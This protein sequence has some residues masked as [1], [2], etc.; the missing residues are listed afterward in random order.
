MLL[1]GKIWMWKISSSSV[2]KCKKKERYRHYKGLSL[3]RNV[4][5]VHNTDIGRGK[6]KTRQPESKPIVSGVGCRRGLTVNSE[7]CRSRYTAILIIFFTHFVLMQRI[8]INWK[9]R[10][11]S[12]RVEYLFVGHIWVM[13]KDLEDKWFILEKFFWCPHK[14]AFCVSR[15]HQK[16]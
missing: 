9:L 8:T 5:L 11:R 15:F 16:N 2:W 10:I 7:Q 3:Q 13:Y 14:A 4:F 1:V 6:I 12:S